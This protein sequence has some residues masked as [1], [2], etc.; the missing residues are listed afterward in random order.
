MFPRSKAIGS[1]QNFRV[2]KQLVCLDIAQLL[3][4]REAH[5][6]KFTV[7]KETFSLQENGQPKDQPFYVIRDNGKAVA[8]LHE[9]MAQLDMITFDPTKTPDQPPFQAYYS[10]G[11]LLGT[12]ITTTPWYGEMWPTGKVEYQF[13]TDEKTLTLK[14]TQIWSK[15]RNARSDYVM[16]LSV[17]PKLGYV[18]DI[19]T[20]LE[21]D[22]GVNAKG[23]PEQ[24]EFFNYQVQV[25]KMGPHNNQKHWPI[26][27]THE[28]TVFFREDDKVVG[29]YIN[30]LANDRSKFKKVKVKDG[31]YVAKLPAADGTG[32]AL[33]HVE[34]GSAGCK[35]NTCNM[36]ADQ[37]NM[38]QLPEKP[39]A[40]GKFRV[41]ATWR[42]LGLPPEVVNGILADVDEM[43]ELGR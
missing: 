38:L 36:W 24:I 12:R 19:Q 40:D 37:H 33:V 42:F 9:A 29:F 16:I 10:W 43:D 6:P 32:V 15:D 2:S 39:D 1:R 35:N 30:P 31:G 5:A 17:D 34:K 22:K 21:T 23:Q 11:K 7:A 26:G 20:S 18:W 14:T 4:V 28:K 25:T 13:T 27:W 8:T 41:K 3:W